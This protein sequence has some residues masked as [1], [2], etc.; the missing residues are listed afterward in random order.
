MQLKIFPLNSN[1]KVALSSPFAIISLCNNFKAVNSNIFTQ[2]PYF[3]F[4]YQFLLQT[5]LPKSIL[6]P[7]YISSV[8]Q[9]LSPGVNQ[10]PHSHSAETETHIYFSSKIAETFDLLRFSGQKAN[11]LH[12]C[13]GCETDS[14]KADFVPGG[15]RLLA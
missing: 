9:S 10:F 7:N 6:S 12:M 1:G 8:P 3:R 15:N 5:I 4:L 13:W 2:S 11:S 14:W